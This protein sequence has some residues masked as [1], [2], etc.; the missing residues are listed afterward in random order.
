MVQIESFEVLPMW[1]NQGFCLVK[2][3]QG[4]CLVEILQ[5]FCP[6]IFYSDYVSLED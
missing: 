6:V 2:I 5:R 4:I 3:L 1:S